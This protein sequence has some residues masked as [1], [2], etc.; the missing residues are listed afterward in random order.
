MISHARCNALGMSWEQNGQRLFHILS[1]A[2]ERAAAP[3]GVLR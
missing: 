1:R 3:R 2:A